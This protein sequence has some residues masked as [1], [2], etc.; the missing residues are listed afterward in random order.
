M[1][2]GKNI[3]CLIATMF[4]VLMP[5]FIAEGRL[6][7]LQAPLYKLQKGKQQVFA[8]S[9]EELEEL[10]KTHAGWEQVRYKGL[11]ELSADDVKNSMLH[12]EH[13]RL[14]VLAIEDFEEAAESLT[15]LMGTKVSDR[16]DFLFENVDFSVLNG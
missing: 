10:K 4:F 16:R 2:D 6:C 8:Y 1:V 7:W 12:P 13:R 15:M 5:D 11:G 3:M 9:A 14:E